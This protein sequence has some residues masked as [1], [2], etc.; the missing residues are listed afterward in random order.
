MQIEFAVV[1]V[2]LVYDKINIMIKV[3]ITGLQ[4]SGKSYISSLFEKLGAKIYNS[5]KRARLLINSIDS[6]KNE[7]VSEFENVYDSNNQLIP[8][9]LK[10]IVFN[11]NKGNILKLNSIVH[12]YIF[13]DF[14]DFCKENLQSDIILAE[15]A[16]L[17]E[18]KMDVLVDRI[19]FVDVPYDVRLSNAIKRDGISKDEYDSR[20]STQL[21]LEFKLLNSDFI[22]DNSELT[23]KSD[24]VKQIY[25]SLTTF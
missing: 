19:I 17:F 15:S 22:I 16:I 9:K 8:S 2:L 21:P 7:I 3:G 6:L 14:Q 5:D 10:D 1:E 13:K 12:P 25:E 20:M 24:K 23:D 4:G 11:T 18:T